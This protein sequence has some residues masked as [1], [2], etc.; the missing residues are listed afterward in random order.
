MRRCR[1][2]PWILALALVLLS[3]TPKTTAKP[4][5]PSTEAP[6]AN[7]NAGI[8][9]E[10][11]RRSAERQDTD[12][13]GANNWVDNCPYTAN[14]DQE[15]RDGDGW[16]D[17]CDRCPDDNNTAG[18]DHGCPKDQVPCVDVCAETQKCD[19][20]I[21]DCVDLPPPPPQAEFAH[22]PPVEACHKYCDIFT[23]CEELETA[24]GKPGLS[25]FRERCHTMCEEDEAG[26]DQMVIVGASRC[27][28]SSTL[29]VFIMKGT[30]CVCGGQYC[31]M[32]MKNCGGDPPMFASDQE[33]YDTCNS[34]PELGSGS[35]TTGNNI[36]CRIYH[37]YYNDPPGACANASP[38]GGTACVN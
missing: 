22:L 11:V 36:R 1:P 25:V 15:N 17:A 37:A 10:T 34:Y 23:E 28:S 20:S 2:N 3:C 33:C 13:D 24:C 9:L 38:S 12:N 19:M 29:Q 4:T 5:T 16:G 21:G 8:D 27:A 26:R 30:E 6:V 32:V 7:T 31:P 35:S 14:P 18:G